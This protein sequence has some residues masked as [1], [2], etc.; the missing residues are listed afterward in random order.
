MTPMTADLRAGIEA[1]A[2]EPWFIRWDNGR[3]GTAWSDPMVRVSDLE[4][5]LAAHPVQDEGA[6]ERAEERRET[7][8]Q[9]HRHEVLAREDEDPDDDPVQ[10][11]TAEELD[12]LP[13]GSVVACWYT[14]G[15][16][17]SVYA[18][19]GDRWRPGWD[20][21]GDDEG[22]Y[23]SSNIMSGP[24]PRPLTVLYRPEVTP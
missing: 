14:D 19:R 17:P 11:T 23:S 10:V 16:G 5:L 20:A 3:T 8:F 12:A 21:T 15:S 1:L 2:A 13:V 22:P 7:A 4:A 18:R 6:E 9:K 24:D